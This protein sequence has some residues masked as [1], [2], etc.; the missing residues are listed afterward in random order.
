MTEDRLIYKP[1]YEKCYC[2]K[3]T[4]RKQNN[5][6]HTCYHWHRNTGNIR[7]CSLCGKEIND[8]DIVNY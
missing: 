2:M 1:Y 7:Y 5:C 3:F 8:M 4:K 6:Y